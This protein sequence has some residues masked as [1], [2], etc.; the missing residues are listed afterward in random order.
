M[1]PFKPQ[2]IEQITDDKEFLRILL[3][4]S[5]TRIEDGNFMALIEQNLIGPFS[6]VATSTTSPK[7]SE[8][9]RA[10]SD[11]IGVVYANISQNN[12]KQSQIMYRIYPRGK[13][14]TLHCTW[15]EIYD[16]NF[17]N[18]REKV[19]R[20]MKGRAIEWVETCFAN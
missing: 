11:C 15:V 2:Q 18:M 8:Q 4:R 20:Q 1:A 6:L 17:S 5:L 16:L 3:K 13:S 19:M 14:L 9:C 7:L 10:N 12:E